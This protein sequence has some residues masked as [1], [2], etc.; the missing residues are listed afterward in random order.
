MRSPSDRLSFA[1]FPTRTAMCRL[2]LLFCVA[3]L[4]SF[5]SVGDSL[6][7]ITYVSSEG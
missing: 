3:F 6:V 7:R 1:S 2:S 5:D 4:N